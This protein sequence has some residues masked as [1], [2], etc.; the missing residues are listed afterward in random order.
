MSLPVLF[1]L[2]QLDYFLLSKVPPP[3]CVPPIPATNSRCPVL[4]PPQVICMGMSA[5]VDSMF[6]ATLLKIA[7]VCVVVLVW[8]NITEGVCFTVFHALFSCAH[9]LLPVPPRADMCCA[10]E[11]WMMS[12]I[13]HGE[14]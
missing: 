11:S 5:K 3:H 7:A 8:R 9:I 10:A 1:V 12:C 6:I 4:M 2:S 14:A 13:I